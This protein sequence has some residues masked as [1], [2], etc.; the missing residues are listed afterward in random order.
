MVFSVKVFSVYPDNS[1]F[2]GGTSTNILM[3][4]V[5]TMMGGLI[6][7]S[8][9]A[10]VFGVKVPPPSLSVSLFLTIWR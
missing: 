9:S 4:Y 2:G 10:G 8:V 3:N 5:L 7:C 6:V 1:I